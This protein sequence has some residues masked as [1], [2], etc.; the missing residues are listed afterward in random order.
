MK[1]KDKIMVN[2]TEL[3]EL[4]GC[5]EAQAR[6]IGEEAKARRRVGNAYRYYLDVVKEYLRK[7][8]F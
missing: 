7:N 1:S 4:L 5:N 6:K 8:L 2:I 3:T